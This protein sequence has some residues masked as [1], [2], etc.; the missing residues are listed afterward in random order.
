MYKFVKFKVY[1]EKTRV[2]RNEKSN[3]YSS[4]II[5]SF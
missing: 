4:N 3:R 2:L 5:N 1:A